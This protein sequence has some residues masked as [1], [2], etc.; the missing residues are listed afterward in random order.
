MTH[1]NDELSSLING[2]L[3]GQL[4]EFD[5]V[6]LQT[7]LKADPAAVSVYVEHV[8]L[9]GQLLWDAGLVPFADGVEARPAIS[10]VESVPFSSVSSSRSIGRTSRI[11]V[12]A[13]ALIALA[14]VFP[15][16][17][18]RTETEIAVLPE[19]V[20]EAANSDNDTGIVRNNS[21]PATVEPLR[22][23][24]LNQSSVASNEL[25]ITDP[26]DRIVQERGP[27]NFITDEAVIAGINR[28]ISQAWRENEVIPSPLAD[29]REWL[30]RG[31]LTF[32]GRIPTVAEIDQF[33]SSRQSG[34]RERMI[35]SLLQSEE[36]STH[37]A[38][39]WT[40]LM[41]G[42]T[43]HRGVNRDALHDYLVGEFQENRPWIDVVG[44]LVSAEGRNDENGAT[45]FLLA[46][47]N[48]DAT[49]AT[50]VTARLFLGQQIQCVQCHDH[51]SDKSI[52]QDDYWA[53]NAFFKQTRRAPVR[54][55]VDDRRSGSM[56][57]VPWKLEDVPGQ[58][59]T[60]FETLQ[61]QQK[62][63]LPRYNGR[64]IPEGSGE[65][66][67]Q[68]LA[69]WLAEDSDKKVARAVVNRMWA[70][71]FGYGFTFPVDDIGPHVTVSHPELFREL[72]TAFIDS[73]Y[74]LQR[75][76]KWIALSAPWQRS[77]QP[78]AGNEADDPQEGGVP[79]FSRM[80]ARRMSPEQVYESIRVAIHSA[81]QQPVVNAETRSDHRSE[82]VRQF[83]R[84]YDTD[85]NDESYNFGGTI[86]QA[87]VMMNGVDVEEALRLATQS[88]VFS[89]GANRD[90]TKDT[91]KRLSMSVLTRDPTPSEETVFRNRMMRELTRSGSR[92]RA[93]SSTVEDMMWAYLNS[94]EFVTV[95]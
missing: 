24:S 47:L 29:D 13:A 89:T 3:D 53:L 94:S 84:S 44:D 86:A 81:S 43:E 58:G 41:I 19:A 1:V 78:V 15:A 11:V 10:R 23:N 51:P 87:M 17:V 2:H 93:L 32:V 61:G 48:N 36:R 52:R 31:Y 64:T 83:V 16:L 18:Q 9:H 7:R 30:R 91:L 82:W 72:T 25:P 55:A 35:E 79:L 69:R 92:E 75:L 95:H 62:A 8:Q 63:V 77:S 21:T 76:M 71:F 12:V 33:T 57:E 67:R 37:L 49:P 90:S 28:L 42:R 68:I 85:E 34:R 40:N 66:R 60:F 39:V 26:G 70:H 54:I 59:M 6:R 14:A 4:T 22:L 38:V 27:E 20:P 80:Y 46:H 50:A 88:V 56:L 45:N 65:G 74:D 5:Q 73:G